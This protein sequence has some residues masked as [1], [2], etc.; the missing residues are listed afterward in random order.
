EV[1]REGAQVAHR[2]AGQ[3]GQGLVGVLQRTAGEAGVGAGLV[4]LGAGL[5]HAGDRGQARFQALVGVVE[6][7]L[8]GGLVGLGRGQRL[9]RHQHVEVGGGGTHHQVVAGGGQVLVGGGAQGALGAQAGE[10]APVEQRLRG[11]QVV[12]A[13]GR[14]G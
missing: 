5:V 1:G 7:A 12:P 11:V 3:L 8:G 4:V 6:L 2:L 9:D 13:G 14:G 10:L